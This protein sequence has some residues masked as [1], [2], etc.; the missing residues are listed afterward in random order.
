M[1][2]TLE[3]TNQEGVK[4]SNKESQDE[5]INIFGKG[6]EFL[7]LPKQELMIHNNKFT[8]N[9][10][11]N[12]KLLGHCYSK[13]YAFEII[14]HEIFNQVK[15]D[16]SYKVE[17][18]PGHKKIKFYKLIKG[19]I[20]NSYQLIDR[21]ELVLIPKLNLVSKMSN[22]DES[23]SETE[24]GSYAQLDEE[25]EESEESSS[26]CSSSSETS[27]SETET[28]YETESE[29]ESYSYEYEYESV[30]E[31]ESESESE[32]SDE[33]QDEVIISNSLFRILSQSI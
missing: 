5:L 16:S 23:E 31:S 29:S 32:S 26:S 4:Y 20:Y 28:E 9:I 6:V 18:Y 13:S 17:V 15:E 30:S 1:S 14:K 25:A 27:P 7:D 3:I 8:V 24:T 22:E 21:F 33:S 2:H 10:Y 12:K 19:Y 11:R